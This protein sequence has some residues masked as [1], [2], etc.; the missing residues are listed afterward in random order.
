MTL[1]K[2]VRESAYKGPAEEADI[3]D[4]Y[5]E[6]F[7]WLKKLLNSVVNKYR[8][9]REWVHNKLTK[10]EPVNL[11]VLSYNQT[12]MPLEWHDF[13]AKTGHTW[14]MDI[15]DSL[16]I[17]SIGIQAYPKRGLG[18]IIGRI[19]HP[20]VKYPGL[21]NEVVEDAI[22]TFGTGFEVTERR[23]EDQKDIFIV[24]RANPRPE[25]IRDMGFVLN[26]VARF[27][28][29]KY[30]RSDTVLYLPEA[31]KEEQSQPVYH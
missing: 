28:E 7:I 8:N 25:T 17:D 15:E 27:I 24:Y 5:G 6:S 21:M 16:Y 1:D 26:N 18:M 10:R 30:E 22:M 11:G 2:L 12:D 13:Y 19:S 9:T 23:S 14:H 4:K 20:R 3:A 31:P 29:R